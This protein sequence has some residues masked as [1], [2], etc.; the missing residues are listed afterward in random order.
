[1]PQGNEYG[2]L[3]HSTLTSLIDGGYGK[4]CEILISQIFAS[5]FNG[6]APTDKL[7]RDKNNRREFKR[8]LDAGCKYR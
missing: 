2:G 6:E 3:G 1:M 7:W 8:Y 4:E 5:V